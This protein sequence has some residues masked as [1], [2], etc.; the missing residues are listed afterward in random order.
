[1]KKRI[2][3]IQFPVKL[4]DITHNQEKVKTLVEQALKEYQP[5]IIL[6]PET[7]NLGFFPKNVDELA[8]DYHTSSSV[9][10]IK[11]LAKGNEVNMV[12]GSIIVKEN[13]L[14][15]NRSIVYDRNGELLHTYDKGHLFSPSKENQSFAAGVKNHVFSIDGVPVAHI[16]CYDLRFPEYIRKL[17]LEGANILFVSAEWPHPRLNH[18]RILN[19]GRAIENQIYVISANGSGTANDLHFCG[20]SAF[21]DPWGE[22]IQEAAEE[23]IILF[24]EIDLN[25]L[26]EARSKIPVFN[27]R[28][29]DLY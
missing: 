26:E 25:K 8:E 21:I 28:N 7:W 6:L 4:G 9:S 16:I 23:E 13:G 3:S 22:T 10:L 14:I 11:E 5:D 18:W 15:R 20:H 29:L 24:S 17:A 12:G 2:V 19:Q 1:M 27:D